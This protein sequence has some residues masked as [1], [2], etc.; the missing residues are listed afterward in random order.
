[1]HLNIECRKQK[2]L[3]ELYFGT[4]DYVI[5]YPD[6]DIQTTHVMEAIYGPNGIKA[7]HLSGKVI[8]N[9]EIAC[10]HLTAK[11]A[12]VIIPG[13]TEIPVVIDALQKRNPFNIIDVNQIYADWAIHFYAKAYVPKQYRIGIIGGLGPSATIDLMDKI[14][15]NHIR[16]K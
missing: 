5:F 2:K 10:E 8:E 9:L 16:G 6:P 3:F 13:F 11:G 4:E 1:L 15:K 7:G 14:I 12:D